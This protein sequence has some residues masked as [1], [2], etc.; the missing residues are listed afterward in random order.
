MDDFNYDTGE[1]QAHKHPPKPDEYFRQIAD[2]GDEIEGV[3]D[4]LQELPHRD[5]LPGRT[6]LSYI[7]IVN[8]NSLFWNDK[9]SHETS[10]RLYSLR[11]VV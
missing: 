5:T 7:S 2:I 9:L 6:L 4:Q 1:N 11:A 3:E 10:R 8:T